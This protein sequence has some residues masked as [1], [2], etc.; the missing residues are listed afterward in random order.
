MRTVLWVPGCLLLLNGRALAG[1]LFKSKIKICSFLLLSIDENIF[2]PTNH[3]LNNKIKFNLGHPT[4]TWC[5]LSH[6]NRRKKKS[7]NSP[8]NRL[9]CGNSKNL[10]KDHSGL[11]S[12]YRHIMSLWGCVIRAWWKKA[13]WRAGESR[14]Q[15]QGD[16]SLDDVHNIP[17]VAG[18]S[19]AAPAWWWKSRL[20]SYVS[21]HGSQSACASLALPFPLTRSLPHLLKRANIYSRC[22]NELCI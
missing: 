15:A 21:H 12:N 14:S 8:K 9:K 1:W 16:I 11:R 10:I 22:W 2:K 18:T 3:N 5:V 20:D 17:F 6:N 4:T 7:K 13:S 19:S